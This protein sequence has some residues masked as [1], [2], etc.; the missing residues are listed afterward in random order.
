MNL[1]DIKHYLVQVKVASLT[2]LCAH[3]NCEAERLRCMLAH[4][5]QKGKVRCFKQSQCGSC[6]Q[7][8]KGQ[9]EIYEWVGV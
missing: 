3:F 4:W 7:C 1:L 9:L 5:Q 2:V 6:T 8:D